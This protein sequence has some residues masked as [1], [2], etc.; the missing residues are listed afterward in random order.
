MSDAFSPVTKPPK[1]MVCVDLREESRVALRLACMKAVARGGSV[2]MIHVIAPA[3]FQTLGAIADRMREERKSEGEQLLATLAD[4]AF[5]NYGIRPSLI[6]R[7]GPTGDEII[8]AS[9]EDHDV[10]MLVIGIASQS[11]GRG[12][13][14]SWLAGQLGNK[15]LTPLLMVPGNLTQQQLQS[16]V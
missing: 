16:L 10:I 7:E 11:S 5:A 6:L 2:S 13:L 12:N 9:L 4:E 3:D 14:A 15:L 1:Y 8:N